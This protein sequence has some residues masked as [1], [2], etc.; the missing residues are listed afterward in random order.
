MTHNS[1]V[2]FK[3]IHFLLWIKGSHQSTNFETFECSGE[4]LRYSSRH[5]PKRKS[6]FLQILHH[7][8]VSWKITP[9][10]FFTSNVIYFV[11]KEP[12]KLEILRIPST[13]VKIH[14][15]LVIFETT[16]KF[17]SNFESLF[18]VKRHKSTIIFYL[19]FYI[20]STKGA[21]QSI[22]LVKFHVSDR[23]AE[24]L[25]FNG[26]L[27]SKSYNVSAKKYRRDI[28]HDTEEW[29]KV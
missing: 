24:I 6:I 19:K 26:F 27:L 16:N 14:Q 25:H 21:Y 22:N 9:L 20:L 18:S 12:I 4:N 5:F 15:I 1:S 17:L 3:L 13:Q 28:S 8:S 2:I 29:R 10:D 7:S 23:K 11:Q